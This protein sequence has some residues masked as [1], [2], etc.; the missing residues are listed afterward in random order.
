MVAAPGHGSIHLVSPSLLQLA[1]LMLWIRCGISSHLDCCVR[2]VF[3]RF[4][5]VTPQSA[6]QE[7]SG[8]QPKMDL[9]M[10]K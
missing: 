10:I 4:C 6:A 3:S 9:S 2:A 5:L 7:A 8:H 1:G